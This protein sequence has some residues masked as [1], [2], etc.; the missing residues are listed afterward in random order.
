MNKYLFLDTETTSDVNLKSKSVHEYVASK[1]FRMLVCCYNYVDTFNAVDEHGVITSHFDPDDRDHQSLR[2]MLMSKDVI[3][4]IHNV[5]FDQAVLASAGFMHPLLLEQTDF[6]LRFIDTSDLAKCIGLKEK[7]LASL[8]ARLG[9]QGKMSEGK[10]LIK[11]FSLKGYKAFEAI[12][13]AHRKEF[14]QFIDYCVQDVA[15]LR[16]VYVALES[17]RNRDPEFF[18]GSDKEL[19]LSA[20]TRATNFKGIKIDVNLL[21]SLNQKVEEVNAMLESRGLNINSTIQLRKLFAGYGYPMMSFDQERRAKALADPELTGEAREMLELIDSCKASSFAKIKVIKDFIDATDG[22][23]VR[24]FLRYCGADTTG[25]WTANNPLQLQNLPHDTTDDYEALE[26]K[27]SE[28][29][30]KDLK[31]LLRKLIVADDQFYCADYSQIEARLAAWFSDNEEMMKAFVEG[32]DA[33]KVMA[34]LMT[35][36]PYEEITKEQ[37]QSGKVAVLSCGYGIGA[38]GLSLNKNNSL[39]ESEAKQ[40]VYAYRRGNQCVVRAWGDV[41][42]AAQ[43]ALA[44][45]PINWKGLDFRKRDNDL[46]IRLHSG[47]LLCFP[48]A[49]VVD[50]Q[51]HYWNGSYESVQHPGGL[52]GIICQSTARDVLAS[53]MIEAYA[54]TGLTPAFSVHDELVYDTRNT[55]KIAKICEALKVTKTFSYDGKNLLEFESF[56]SPYYKKA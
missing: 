47:R 29:S 55:S 54:L 13:D 7:S 25:R 24:G 38:R 23:R 20:M 36:V 53:A 17:E 1:D 22:D 56:I 3:K 28:A 40:I 16:E 14:E 4:V 30:L 5:Q 39:T 19:L 33:Y 10:D 48:E 8:A 21:G 26:S 52:F 11:L 44:G 50:D 18:S 12:I 37:R 46:L 43:K 31:P 49:R 51:L 34:S 32:K 15:V 45:K 2:N 42:R 6:Q 9:C 35:G 27:I 41:M